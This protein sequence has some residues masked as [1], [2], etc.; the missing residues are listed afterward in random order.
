MDHIDADNCWCGP[1]LYAD[2]PGGEIW[3]H[4]VPCDPHDRP[5]REMLLE[6]IEENL[7]PNN[8]PEDE[9]FD[10]NFVGLV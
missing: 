7:S 6:S 2:L 5:P 4:R 10:P 8:D 9:P 3:I 1:I